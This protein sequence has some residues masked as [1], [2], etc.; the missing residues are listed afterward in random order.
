MAVGA[1]TG[2][3][4]P[5]PLLRIDPDAEEPARDYLSTKGHWPDA[6]I[7]SSARKLEDRTTRPAPTD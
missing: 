7:N 3:A 5:E 6:E 2:R 4:A 1:G